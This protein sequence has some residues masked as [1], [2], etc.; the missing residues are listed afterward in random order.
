MP[1]KKPARTQHLTIWKV[2]GELLDAIDAVAGKG[3]RSG[4][5]LDLVC[6]ELGKPE[7]VA[8]RKKAGRPKKAE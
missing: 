7:F 4:W 5:I 3:N 1:K 8:T 6:R 2:P